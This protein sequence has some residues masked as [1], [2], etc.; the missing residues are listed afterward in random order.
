LR[1]WHEALLLLALPVLLYARGLGYGLLGVDDG[2]YY[3]NGA[4][5]GGHWQGLVDVWK[6]PF[7]NEYFPVTAITNWLDLALFGLGDLWGARLHHLLWF[8]AGALFVWA[9]VLRLTERR[10]LALAVAL[11]YVL[12][13]VCTE[14]A[15]WMGQRKGLVAFALSFWSL[16]RYL[17]ARQ[18][19][20]RGRQ[21]RLLAAA[22]LLAVL[23][24]FGKT[25]AVAVPALL[26]AYELTL[27]RGPW[28]QRAACL[29]PFVL[30]AGIFSVL[31]LLH[32][33]DLGYP[34]LGGSRA[35]AFVTTGPI[36]LRYLGH[37]LSPVDLAFYYAVPELPLTAVRG[38]AAWASV[39]VLAALS[40]WAAHRRR[41]VACGWLLGFAGLSP[42]LNFLNQ[43]LPMTDHYQ[44]WALPGWLL[45]LAVLVQDGLTAASAPRAAGADG[46]PPTP[47]FTKGGRTATG[48][49]G[50]SSPRAAKAGVLLA[51]LACAACA[52]ACFVRV[53]EFQSARALF[54]RAVERQPEAAWNWAGRLVALDAARGDGAGQ[55][56]DARGEIGAVAMRALSCPD[57]LRLL[58][59]DR[60]LAI[61]CAAL[62]LHREGRADEARALADRECARLSDELTRELTWAEVA[63]R[64]GRPAEAL[65]RLAPYF[66]FD[67]FA[68]QGLAELRRL[69]RDGARLPD[70]APPV[71]E[72]RAADADEFQ[73]RNA[74]E[75]F[76]LGLYLLAYAARENGDV[77]RAF[78][79]A[80]LLV[81]MFPNDARGRELLAEIYQQSGLPNAAAALRR[82]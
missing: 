52:A 34:Y 53:P 47:P 35:A 38:W 70:A 39:A 63:A 56:G 25:H 11:L 9:V 46:T 8:G 62:W 27:G 60:A 79:C 51:G 19:G 32:R 48:P 16:E 1:S 12:H 75:Q 66:Q 82:G 13:P 21:L 37:M 78:D 7:C 29:S 41:L 14:S 20:T 80:A 36:V 30:A 69:C 77:E 22:W 43:L 57:S 6:G 59:Q 2:L 17:A 45:V 18:A 67:S 42:A 81:N 49:A 54:T 55:D 65:A 33:Q 28:L 76:Q 40:I 74:Q 64:T 23:A 73:R 10:G 50:A 3:S 44:Q 71:R 58:P 68:Q 31:N 4:L 24:L 5:H 72:F 61:R 15:L 26:L